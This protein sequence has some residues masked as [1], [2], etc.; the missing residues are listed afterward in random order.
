MDTIHCNCY[1]LNNPNK[2][3]GEARKNKSIELM[4]EAILELR[5]ASI[6]PTIM[7]V[8]K[9][10]NGQLGETTIKKYWRIVNP[11]SEITHHTS[12]ININEGNNKE[13]SIAINKVPLNNQQIQNSPIP[14]Q[15]LVELY[16]KEWN[17][18]IYSP[19]YFEITYQVNNII[20]NHLYQMQFNP[21]Y[22]YF[23]IPIYH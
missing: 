23:I 14:K 12:P 1:K 18:K 11:K 7:K 2:R 15:S 17:L 21:A 10:L 5:N 16:I 19:K 3:T 22:N 8:A 6:K 20:A 4:Q 9:V 13:Q